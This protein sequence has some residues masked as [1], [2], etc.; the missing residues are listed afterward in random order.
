MKN[1]QSGQLSVVRNDQVE[2]YKANGWNE[3]K[4]MRRFKSRY[5]SRTGFKTRP[6][7]SKRS[8]RRSVRIKRYGATRGGIRL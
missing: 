2:K 3:V 8:I 5:K 7:R 6:K 1:N 4:K